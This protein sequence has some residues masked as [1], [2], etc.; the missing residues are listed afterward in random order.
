MDELRAYLKS[1]T[2]EDRVAFALRSGTTVGY[3]QKAISTSQRLSAQICINLELESGRA[4]VCEQLRP[5]IRWAEWEQL[6][7]TVAAP[8][9]ADPTPQPTPPSP[10]EPQRAEQGVSNV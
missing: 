7:S 5:D 9:Q 10:P 3:L 8:A 1:L 6:R 2:A 4:V